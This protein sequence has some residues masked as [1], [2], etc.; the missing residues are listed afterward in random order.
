MGHIMNIGPLSVI[1]AEETR[2][3]GHQRIVKTWRDEVIDKS[4][5]IQ[6]VWELVDKTGIGRSNFKHLLKFKYRTV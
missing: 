1:Q 6:N 3:Q 2:Q 4:K 5:K